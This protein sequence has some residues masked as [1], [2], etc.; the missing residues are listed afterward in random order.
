MHTDHALEVGDLVVHYG[1]G[2]DRFAAVRGVELT[3]RRGTTVGLVGESGSGKSTVARTIA[4]LVRPT[5]G[6]V[7]L[8]GDDRLPA[9]E[10]VQMIFQDPYGSLNPRMTVG[11]A[12]AEA[13]RLA[14]R[15]GR[16]LVFGTV[17]ELLAAVSLD[18]GVAAKYPAT[19][20]GGQRQRVAIARAICL[21][22]RLIVADEITSALDVSVQGA[23]L[24]LVRDLQ[25]RLDLS[26]L[27]VSHNLAVVRYVCDY[28]YVMYAGQIV[29]HGPVE[30]VTDEPRHPYTRGLLA[31]VPDL[32]PRVTDDRD[33]V[34]IGDSADPRR[35]PG[36]C[37]FQPRCPLAARADAAVCRESP[38]AVAEL[39]DGRGV[40]CHFPIETPLR[41]T[42]RQ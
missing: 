41:P 8:G 30:S 17:P 35:L 40:A 22:P 7:E 34:P 32:D 23:T 1:S 33:W 37:S 28:L 25:R 3:I 42:I 16:E 21:Q 39:A 13:L 20:S 18:A 26:M 19:M 11:Q 15:S 38:P 27:F 14:G 2:G 31:S 36:G 5:S 10:Q 9:R 24:N 4:G 29:E 12:L 6:R